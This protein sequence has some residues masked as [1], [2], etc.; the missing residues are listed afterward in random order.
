MANCPLWRFPTP[1]AHLRSSGYGH[2]AAIRSGHPGWRWSSHVE[3][4][5]RPRQSYPEAGDSWPGSS[6]PGGDFPAGF[7]SE[8][9]IS[10]PRGRA[11]TLANAVMPICVAA[12]P[13]PVFAAELSDIRAI[14]FGGIGECGG[15]IAVRSPL[16]WLTQM[17]ALLVREDDDGSEAWCR[18]DGRGGSAGAGLVSFQGQ[19]PRPRRPQPSRARRRAIRRSR[20]SS[21]GISR[22]HTGAGSRPSRPDST[23]QAWG[24]GA[25]S[26]P[27]RIST[28]PAWSRP[29]FSVLSSARRK[30]STGT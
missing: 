26:T 6:F 12:F 14:N 21:A 23:I 18:L 9:I 25:G 30:R 4:P 1:S 28:R 22:P 10:P 2:S 8:D 15:P 16:R 19:R 11:Q 27:T 13:C 5:S 17:I 3:C 29:P 20:P 7:T 24:S